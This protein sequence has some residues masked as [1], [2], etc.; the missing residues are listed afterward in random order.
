MNNFNITE[1]CQRSRSL[2]SL[3][4]KV[5]DIVAMNSGAEDFTRVRIFGVDYMCASGRAIAYCWDPM[6]EEEERAEVPEA[7]SASGH[8]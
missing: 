4:K 2:T 1:R 6:P 3:S 5:T 7:V 8:E